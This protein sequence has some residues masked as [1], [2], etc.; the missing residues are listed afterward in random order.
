VHSVADTTVRLLTEWSMIKTNLE[1][2]QGNNWNVYEGNMYTEYSKVAYEQFSSAVNWGR[3]LMF[4]GFSVSFCTYAL[5][6]DVPVAANSVME[7]TCQVVEED[8]AKF[9]GTNGG[10]VSVFVLE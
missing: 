9:F 10:W 8:L 3:F 7:W 1:D 2:F 6:R 4:V 5:E